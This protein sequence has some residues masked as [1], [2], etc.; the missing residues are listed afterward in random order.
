MTAVCWQCGKEKRRAFSV[1]E[2]CRAV[3]RTE[4]EMAISWA[5]SSHCL[6]GPALEQAGDRIAAGHP[7]D[8]SPELERTLVET[9]RTA[10]LQLTSTR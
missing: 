7:M 2:H 6:D 3:P 1:C 5:L 10:L 9:M 8:L 4:E